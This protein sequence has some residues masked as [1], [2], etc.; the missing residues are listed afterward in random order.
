MNDLIVYNKQNW[1]AELLNG[2]LLLKG[3]T[4]LP[5][6]P[7]EI[8]DYP[9]YLKEKGYAATTIAVCLAPVREAYAMVGI[10]TKRIIKAPAGPKGFLKD[11]VTVNDMIHLLKYMQ[12][13]KIRDKAIVYLCA[14]LGLRDVEISRLDAGDFYLDGEGKHW[15]RIWGKYRSC[16]D[17][18][19]RVIN[20]DL[21]T[22][23]IQYQ[24]EVLIQR[25]EKDAMFIGKKGKRLRPDCVSRLISGIMKKAGV[26]ISSRITPHSIRH[27]AGTQLWYITRDIRLV[28]RFLRHSDIKTTQRY[29]HD[30]IPDDNRP[31][32]YVRYIE[33]D[34]KCGENVATNMPK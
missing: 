16:K 1:I 11:A 8:K 19:F 17:D 24:N 22:I 28:Q 23:M 31:E 13:K 32:S 14:Y 30:I 12:D 34:F 10:N 33:E 4:I 9:E 7:R 5:Q 3:L 29:L 27:G 18:K 6:D 21:L 15:L 20:S 26:K 25:Q 2:Y